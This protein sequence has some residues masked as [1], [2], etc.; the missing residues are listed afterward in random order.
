MKR[1]FLT[2]EVEHTGASHNEARAK[3]G[4]FKQTNEVE[5]KEQPTGV[6]LAESAETRRNCQEE[7]DR[8]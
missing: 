6:S 3:L 5:T 7:K 8:E 2:P 4:Q 1:L